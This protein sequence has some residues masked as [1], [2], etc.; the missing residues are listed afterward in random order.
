MTLTCPACGSSRTTAFL[1]LGEAPV[2]C[3]VQWTSRAQAQAATTGPLALTACIDC[4][5]VFNHAFDAAR[6]AYAPGYE[7]SQHASS[8]FR[9]YAEK[10]VDRLIEVYGIR[11]RSVVDIG[12][13]RGDLL[14]LMCE[15][16][17]NRGYGFDP[18]YAGSTVA[19]GDRP[20]TIQR[21]YF[22]AEHA[23]TIRPSLV[24]CRHVLEHVEDP[25]AF[26]RTLRM[27]IEACGDAVLY[28][29][30][31]SGEE[32]LE[33]NGL[34]DYLYEHVSYFSAQSLEAVLH[35]AGF[36]VLTMRRDFGGQ[37]LCADAR[38][39]RQ[40]LPAR[41]PSARSEDAIRA[42]AQAMLE[43]LE[44]WKR[45]A[46]SLPAGRTVSM[47]GAGSKGVMFLNLL[48]LV[49]P[50]RVD[51]VVDQNVD[52]HGRF[53]SGTGQE[54]VAPEALRGGDVKQIV[55]MNGIYESEVRGRLQNL[56]IDAELTVAWP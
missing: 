16:G 3:N 14:A 47:W 43:R 54:I 39:A 55:L 27:A 36:E 20:F 53:V 13:G 28:L 29:E 19:A 26:L 49:A 35:A 22:G 41:A 9:A 50:Q 45:W 6:L 8:V 52:K 7:N 4:G 2:F 18:S 1:E 48:G 44:H 34:W 51:R 42:A 21:E 25:I 46:N 17:G 37:F 10:L 5:H 31:P 33:S 30:V 24:S 32:L 15:R 38:V 12:C 23:A 56:G 11:D 40:P